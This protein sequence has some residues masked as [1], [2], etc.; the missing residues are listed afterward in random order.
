[1]TPLLKIAAQFVLGHDKDSCRSVLLDFVQFAKSFAE[2]TKTTIDD[3]ILEHIE[4]ML[5][6]EAL[7]DYVYR[8]V[9]GRF[10]TEAILFE[11]VDE[12]IVAELLP[13]TPQDEPKGIQ[14]AVILSIVTKI[15]AL[16]DTMRDGRPMK[17]PQTAADDFIPAVEPY[18]HLK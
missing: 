11:S 4:F 9:A 1:M 12:N 3:A 8:L 6:N 14:L 18:T 5:K 15:I 13:S 7:F 16:I 17:R 2:T 10:Q